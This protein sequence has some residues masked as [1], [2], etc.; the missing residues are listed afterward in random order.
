[1][2]DDGGFEAVVVSFVFAQVKLQ[3]YMRLT[4]ALGIS[5]GSK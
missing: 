1:V 4:E 2:L 3:R 5:S